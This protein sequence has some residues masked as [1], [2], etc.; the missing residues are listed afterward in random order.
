MKFQEKQPFVVITKSLKYFY[1]TV[2]YS[3]ELTE[4]NEYEVESVTII[5]DHKITAED[6]GNIV[7]TFVRSKYSIDDVEAIQLNILEEESEKHLQELNELQE[8]RKYSKEKAKE[9]IEYIEKNFN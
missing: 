4:D 3:Q 5:L 1:Y 6:Y 8:W 2:N 9:I 7:S